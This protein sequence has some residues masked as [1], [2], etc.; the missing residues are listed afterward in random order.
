[1]KNLMNTL[2]YE[3]AARKSMESDRL[4]NLN[5]MFNSHC[6]LS[7]RRRGVCDMLKGNVLVTFVLVDDL[8]SSWTSADKDRFKRIQNNASRRLEDEAKEYGAELSITTQFI[9][10]ELAIKA[11]SVEHSW[12]DVALDA[13][14]LY[15][16]NETEALK[17]NGEF[18][19]APIIFAL[20]KDGRGHADNRKDAFEYAV[21]YGFSDY[22][23]ELL[24][25]FGAVDFYLPEAVSDFA[26]K[27]FNNSIMFGSDDGDGNEKCVD[28]FTAY[29]IGWTDKV[30]TEA[31]TF[32]QDTA[33]LT[34]EY[35]KAESEK[36][37]F[38]GFKTISTPEYEYTGYFKNG[39]FHGYGN[40]IWHDKNGCLSDYVGFWSNGK[41][42]GYG[43]MR[44]A[45]GCI[46]QGEWTND[47]WNGIGACIFPR[48]EVCNGELR[49]GKMDGKGVCFYPDGSTYS[50][51]WEEHK[52]N[53]HGIYRSASGDVYDGY[54]HNDMKQGLGVL[55]LTNGERFEGCWKNDKK[56]GFGVHYH[57]DGTKCEGIWR[58]D[59]YM[60]NYD[61]RLA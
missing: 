13:V 32:I 46:Y 45:D 40:M 43:C 36:N 33:C 53:G 3:D 1:M 16:G 58:N 48:G 20:N 37:S 41:R 47:K 19:E 17:N 31:Y 44:Y 56:N 38:T 35:L 52:K 57:S 21:I 2:R 8:G 18:N 42:S 30:S 50:G 51:E 15:G 60:G 49:N 11:D 61:E 7:G 34:E 22:R 12:M 29:L 28:S 9:K 54:W 26:D 4:P 24:H 14:G 59:V 10:C 27:H 39:V 6:L 5:S 23:H 25:L 55:I